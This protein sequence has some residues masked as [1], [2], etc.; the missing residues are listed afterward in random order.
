ML[1]DHAAP[2]KRQQVRTRQLSVN[3]K[4]EIDRSV[5]NCYCIKHKEGKTVTKSYGLV[6]GSILIF[7][8]FTL[9]LFPN[10]KEENLPVERLLDFSLE[11][12][13][14]LE[15]FDAPTGETISLTKRGGLWYFGNKKL[16][17]EYI[18][19][20]LALLQE[21]SAKVSTDASTSDQDNNPIFRITLQTETG[22]TLWLTVGERVS[23]S[24][25]C[26]RTSQSSELY[27]L[28]EY[29]LWQLRDLLNQALMV[30]PLFHS[31]LQQF[32]P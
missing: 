22:A 9:A 1:P 14:S 15:I 12:V 19:D 21:I 10:P 13:H 4:E 20:L 3:T 18:T 7:A 17:D 2:L 30:E 24:V 23:K 25:Y 27:L 31:P 5:A 26:T 6:I 28:D 8:L 11:S 32:A 16:R 29:S